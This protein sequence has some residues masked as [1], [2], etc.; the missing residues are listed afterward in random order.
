MIKSLLAAALLGSL[1]VSVP[2]IP[3]Q[4][5]R[6]M[7][8]GVAPGQLI[9]FDREGRPTILCP[10]AG[11][12][13]SA[14]I[15]GF[16]ARVT[17]KQTFTNPTNEPI[18]AVYTFP[19]PDDGAV[20]QMRL[21]VGDRV[22]EA[23]I[24]RREEARAIYD[25]AKAAGKVATLLDQER[26][27]VF[28]QSVSN[29]M[30]KAKV[31]VEIS[32]VHMVKY[33]DGQ[34]EFVYPMV[35]GPR[36]AMQATDP[37]K[38]T[39]PTLP[40]NVRSGSSTS[41]NVDVR[42]GS[43]VGPVTSVLHDVDVRRAGRDRFTVN[44][45]RK[46][47][48]PNR[49]FVL[50]YRVASD[51]VQ[52]SFVAHWDSER[53]MG[54]FNLI[55]L[56]PVEPRAEQITAK[57]VWFVMDQSGSQSGFPIEKSKELTLKMLERAN[58][59]DRF[60]V[61][62][63]STSQNLLWPE[64]RP[65]TPQNLAEAKR[66]VAAMEARG[67]T[68][69]L[70]AVRSVLPEGEAQHGK[71]FVVFNTDGYVG[72]EVEIISA[73]GQRIGET[74]IFTFG[75]GNGV[76]R[77]LINAMSTYG[78][79][80]AEVVM[81]PEKADAAVER[82]LQR[83]QSP[84]LTD[85]EARFEG[86]IA[87]VTPNLI[88]DVFSNTPIVI[89]GRYTQPGRATVTVQGLIAGVPWAKEIELNLP[90]RSSGDSSLPSTWARSRLDDL[91]AEALDTKRQ[92]PA[93]EQATALA[94][95]YRLLS[96]YTSFVAVEQRIVNVGGKQR[97]VRVPVE[98]ADGVTLGLESRDAANGQKLRIAYA[99]PLNLRAAPGGAGT[100]GAQLGG[101]GGGGGSFAARLETV[102]E[103]EQK[104]SPKLANAKGTVEVQVWLTKLDAEVEQELK[105]AGLNIDERDGKL[106]IVF[107]TIAASKLNGLSKLTTVL[108]ISP[109]VE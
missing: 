89:K 65:V 57:E 78:R 76:N 21:K 60:N 98:M 55:L 74:R 69:I 52:S 50:R 58:P 90:G 67:G 73:I 66:F 70:E 5:H 34:F 33:E 31:E 36:N 28:T 10:L 56:P 103:Q 97:R 100:R 25:E 8:E 59:G 19:L 106:R 9:G 105:R 108:K 37:E 109:L 54:F 48:M 40:P 18:E 49:D 32:Y 87:D 12:E 30:P 20:D 64:A 84:V 81:L 4:S 53:K 91:G 43:S 39:P 61:M 99:T 6:V 63:F 7:D 3:T 101:L 11:T 51:E 68:N 27:N 46:D 82:F 47:E 79:G 15:D 85:V 1:L 77:Y 26:P 24:K 22:I 71:R 14:S 29:I 102:L 17:L 13:V 16:A 38:I 44:L 104:I 45:K 88:P 94:L 2:P 42:A 62:G 107:G 35:V 95:E 80:A 23:E 92:A 93:T 86:P 41:L 83:L 75:I 72:N 96:E